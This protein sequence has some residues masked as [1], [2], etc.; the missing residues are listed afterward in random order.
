MF[1]LFNYIS[2]CFASCLLPNSG[3]LLACDLCPLGCFTMHFFIVGAIAT[4]SC[5]KPLSFSCSD[6]SLK[7]FYPPPPQYLHFFAL[8]LLL[9]LCTCLTLIA[10]AFRQFWVQEHKLQ[11]QSC[12]VPAL[13]SCT[14]KMY[15]LLEC[16]TF[17]SIIHH[18][19]SYCFLRHYRS[20]ETSFFPWIWFLCTSFRR[21]TTVFFKIRKCLVQYLIKQ[22]RASV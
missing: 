11:I 20:L 9:C 12:T 7:H 13:L 10:N 4:F 22:L 16:K 19:I 14:D 5:T 15:L 18:F 1:F 2:I 6:T 21:K 3:R 17:F 8:E